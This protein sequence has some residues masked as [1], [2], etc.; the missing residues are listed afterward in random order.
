MSHTP[1]ERI[2]IIGFGPVAASLIEG[3]LPG[4]SAGQIEL[5]VLG[6]EP[7]P[8]YNRVLLAEVAVGSTRTEHLMLSD[9][10]RL[11]DAGVRVLSGCTATRVDRA[12]RK[13]HLATGEP[14]SYDR[15]IFATGAR[16]MIPSLHGVNFDPHT[17]P[18]LPEGVLALRTLEDAL[19]LQKVL[20]RRGRVLILGGGILGL[21]AALAMAAAGHTPVLIHHGPAPL[22]RMMDADGGR[23]LLRQ[24][25]EAGVEVHSQVRATG[26]RLNEN[27]FA[28]L[29][30]ET[31]GEITGDALL[32]S[33]GVRARTE[34]AAGCGLEVGRGIKT[35]E[36]LCADA[37]HRIFALGDCA[38][39]AGT[40][41]AGLL[42]PGWAQAG[43]LANYLLTHR[44]PRP[45]RAPE[46]QSALTPPPPFTA[47]QVL[48]LKGQGLELTAAGDIDA[49]LFAEDGREVMVFADPSRGCYLKLVTRDSVALGFVALGLPRTSAELVLAFER[50]AALPEDRSLLLRLDDPGL[51]EPTA[52]AADE[53]TLCRCS[54]A[55]YGDVAHAVSEG[56]ETVAEVGESCRAGTGCGGCREKIEQM[57]QRVAIPA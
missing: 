43:W 31:H 22:G 5:T 19:S 12:R 41:P 30:T 13:V 32:I 1:S 53:D 35:D 26:V 50:G 54:G 28:A 40:A 29:G 56:C 51:S 18:D 7:Q 9:L 34:L 24:L 57:L 37:E 4:V 15:L 33:T 11:R 45:D 49:P 23:L 38:E 2:L 8:A 47:S 25:S 16:A 3:L 21:E 52:A 42:A 39:V 46:P 55:T 17:E 10:D 44:A 6:A 36:Y 14:L 20:A 48:M 27:G